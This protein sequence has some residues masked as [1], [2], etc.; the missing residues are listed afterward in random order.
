[1]L[2]EFGLQLL[3]FPFELVL[4]F[5]GPLVQVLVVSGL[6]A[7][8]DILGSQRAVPTTRR[9]RRETRGLTLDWRTEELA[10]ADSRYSAHGHFVPKTSLCV[11]PQMAIPRKFLRLD[12]Q[13]P[14][15]DEIVELPREQLS[16][17]FSE[18]LLAR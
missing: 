14:T 3:D 4:S 18:Q 17:L 15:S 2:L 8:L 1:M 10:E 9:P 11:Q 12:N 5:A 16:G 6:L 7:K 13:S